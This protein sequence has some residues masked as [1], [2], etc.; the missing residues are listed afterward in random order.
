MDVTQTCPHD[1]QNKMDTNHPSG[2]AILIHI[3][4]A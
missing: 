1:N 2:E 4:F 3:R